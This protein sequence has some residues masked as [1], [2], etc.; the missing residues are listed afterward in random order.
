M[1]CL[2]IRTLRRTSAMYSKHDISAHVMDVIK[3]LQNNN[4]IN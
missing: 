1:T 2:H 3:E 4:H